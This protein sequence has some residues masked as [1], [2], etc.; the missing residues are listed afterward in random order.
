MKRKIL[1]KAEAARVTGADRPG[2]S[3]DSDCCHTQGYKTGN[4]RK[5]RLGIF[6]YKEEEYFCP[7]CETFFYRMDF[8]LFD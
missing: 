2:I 1:T 5:I 6:T 8:T 3:Y 7:S 4:W